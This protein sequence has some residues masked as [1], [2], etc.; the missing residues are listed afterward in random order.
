MG[1]KSYPFFKG[2]KR[3]VKK[4][5]KKRIPGIKITGNNNKVTIGNKNG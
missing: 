5:F 4:I 3:I 2:I 1:I